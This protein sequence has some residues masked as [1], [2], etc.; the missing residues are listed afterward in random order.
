MV[1]K[2][3]CILILYAQQHCTRVIFLQDFNL[4]VLDELVMHVAEMYRQDVLALPHDED[5]NKGKRFAA[6]RQFRLWHNGRFG[7]G[8]R[9]R[10][11]VFS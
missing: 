7:V 10:H 2:I 9:R 1:S 4:L 11:E 3:S 8:V 5:Y 6:Y